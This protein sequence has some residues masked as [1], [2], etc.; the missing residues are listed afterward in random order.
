MLHSGRRPIARWH[1]YPNRCRYYGDHAVCTKDTPCSNSFGP[2]WLL[3]WVNRVDG[4]SDVEG[5]DGILI[6]GYLVKTWPA[7]AILEGQLSVYQAR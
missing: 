1:V 4:L 5:D 3:Y 7:G 6:G 2:P